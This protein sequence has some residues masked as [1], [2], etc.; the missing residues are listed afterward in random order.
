MERGSEFWRFSLSLYRMDGVPPSCIALQDRH[1]LDVN[2][3]LFAL[4]LASKGRAI[5]APDMQQA[6]G[7]VRDWRVESVVALR[8]VRRFLRDPPPPFAGE[9]AHALRDKIKSAELESERLQQEALFAMRPPE[10]WGRTE[11]PLKAA[12]LNLDACA[13]S[14]GAVFDDG[15]RRAL[16]DA[17]HAL[18][19]ARTP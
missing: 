7:L 10:A 8:G 19:A 13:Q 16:L 2:I 4:W 15:A 9:A 6:D 17:F 11:E 5:S 1:G 12:E 14:I 18:V 3:M